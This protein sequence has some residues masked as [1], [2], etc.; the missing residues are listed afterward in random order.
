MAHIKS[1]DITINTQQKLKGNATQLATNV[2][3]YTYGKYV[4][5]VD[6][7]YIACRK[8]YT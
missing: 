6:S 5:N 7:V 4:S 3:V 8:V 1:F 2:H